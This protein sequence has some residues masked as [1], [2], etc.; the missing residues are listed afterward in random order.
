MLKTLGID[1]EQHSNVRAATTD[2]VALLP[3]VFT[4]GDIWRSNPS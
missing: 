2:L 4:A 1:L 3:R